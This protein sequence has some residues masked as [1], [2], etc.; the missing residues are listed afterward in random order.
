MAM[1]ANDSERSA[2]MSIIDAYH[3][4][5]ISVE[6]AVSQAEGIRDAKNAYH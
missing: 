4:K 5:I 1:G 2:L 6:D 3:K